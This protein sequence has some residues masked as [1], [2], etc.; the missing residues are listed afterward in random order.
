MHTECDNNTSTDVALLC[1]N[2][3]DGW[4]GWMDGSPGGGKYRA[5]YGA[6]KSVQK[7]KS[8]PNTHKLH[9]GGV[10]YCCQC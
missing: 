4:D 3:M 9:T 8:K 7:S 5:P 10:L 6:F 1:N 2:C